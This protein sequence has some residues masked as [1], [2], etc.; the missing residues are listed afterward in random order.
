MKIGADM[1]KF[2]HMGLNSQ[3]KEKLE[4]K[5]LKVKL[6]TMHLGLI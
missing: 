1:I 3:N 5:T 4:F 2:Y 6:S